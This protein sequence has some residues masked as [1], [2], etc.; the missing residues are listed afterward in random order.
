VFSAH[1]DVAFSLPIQTGFPLDAQRGAIALA[2]DAKT[3]KRF[4]CLKPAIKKGLKSPKKP[5][6]PG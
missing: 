5:D 3:R 4:A 2:S 1:R 6:K